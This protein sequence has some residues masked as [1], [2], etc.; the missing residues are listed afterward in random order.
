MQVEARQP[1]QPVIGRLGVLVSQLG[2]IC[3]CG[4]VRGFVLGRRYPVAYSSVLLAFQ[5]HTQ[6]HSLVDRVDVH[7][8]HLDLL[9]LAEQVL[10]ALA[11]A[12]RHLRSVDQAPSTPRS[13][14]ANAP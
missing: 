11:L 10:H 9:T 14:H 6:A 2:A 4:F 7:H 12:Q 1:P 3:H 5:L 8:T 13:R